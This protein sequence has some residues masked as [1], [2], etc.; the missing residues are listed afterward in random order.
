MTKSPRA[1][2]REALRLAREA[3]PAYSSKFSRKDFT[4][5]QL[6]AALALK[7]FFKTDYRGVVQM[8]A[9]F[10]ELRQELGLAAAPALLD[11]LLR[12]QA[13]AK[14]GEFV[15]L[16]FRATV[17]AQEGGLIGAKPTAAVDA[18]GMESR[19]TSRYFFK[20]AGRKHNSRLWTKLAVACETASHFFTAARV[21]LGPANDA[22]PFRPL[23]AQASLAV[24]Y[25][26]VLGRR[27]LRQR[28]EPPLRPGG[29]GRPL[30]GDPAEPAE[31]GPEVAQDSL[32]AADGQAV[33]QEAAG[34]PAPARVRAALAGG[35]RLLPAQAAARLGPA[36]QVGCVARARV[37]P[38]CPHPQPHAP[39]R[40]R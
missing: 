9:D 14:K 7:T 19:H 22:P 37:L 26:R 32:P 25:D 20:R 16:L 4:Q 5:H 8:L 6:F 24:D 33:P 23:M 29:P 15:V 17:R 36:G 21:S 1:V 40:Y 18:T 12:R 11:P 39:R 27:G 10:A 3:L 34:Q 38:A 13:A 31:P 35:E 2:A 30:D 28:G